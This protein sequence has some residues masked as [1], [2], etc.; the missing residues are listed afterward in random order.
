MKT[1]L[2]NDYHLEVA[3]NHYSVPAELTGQVVEGRVTA[4][5]SPV[6]CTSRSRIAGMPSG[7]GRSR[8]VVWRPSCVTTLTRW[9]SSMGPAAAK[10]IDAIFTK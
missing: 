5:S 3:G 4:M 7:L 10:S 8:T 2:Q 1:R 9:L 6:R